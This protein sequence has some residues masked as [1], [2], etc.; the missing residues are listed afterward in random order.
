[1]GT[2]KACEFNCMEEKRNLLLQNSDFLKTP[3]INYFREVRIKLVL[4]IT[5]QEK[6]NNETIWQLNVSILSFI[7]SKVRLMAWERHLNARNR[8]CWCDALEPLTKQSNLSTISCFKTSLLFILNDNIMFLSHFF[9]VNNQF[10]SVK[11]QHKKVP[12]PV[13]CFW[14]HLSPVKYLVLWQKLPNYI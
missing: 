1:M 3:Q 8:G 5:E 7:T 2:G 4:V 11:R 6:K 12:F 9:F 10:R 14:N 13:L